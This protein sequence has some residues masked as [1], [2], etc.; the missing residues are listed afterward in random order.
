MHYIYEAYTK[1]INGDMN[2]FVKKFLH[3]PDLPQLT[4]LLEGYGMHTDFQKACRIAGIED[5]KI[6]DRIMEQVNNKVEVAK[7]IDMTSLGT[8]YEIQSRAV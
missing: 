7:V 2:Y 4:D 5:A 3:F 8:Q 1:E 6:M